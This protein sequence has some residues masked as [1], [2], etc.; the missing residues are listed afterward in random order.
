MPNLIDDDSGVNAMLEYLITFVFAFIMFTMLLSMFDGMFI[1]G[2]ERTVSR[3]QFADVGNDVTAKI[4]DTYLIAPATGNVSTV[5]E[6]PSTAAGKDYM[7][8]IRTCANGWDKEI[9]VYSAHTDVNMSVTLNGV[10][11]TIPIVGSTS[12]SSPVHRVRYDS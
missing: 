11:S 4:L 5:F 10:N 1:A 6:M 3:I 2:P 8:D 7:L 12:S 9:V